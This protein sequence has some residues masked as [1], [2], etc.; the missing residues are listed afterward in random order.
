MKPTEGWEGVSRGLSGGGVLLDCGSNTGVVQ[1][2]GAD[3]RAWRVPGIALE[4]KAEHV[5]ENEVGN[6]GDSIRVW[7]LQKVSNLTVKGFLP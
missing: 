5:R 1:A 3:E 6:T 2:L 4:A 7:Y